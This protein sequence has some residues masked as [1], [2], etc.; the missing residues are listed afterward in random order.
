M[1]A[2]I[3]GQKKVIADIKAVTDGLSSGSVN[4]GF[5]GAERYPDG[6]PVAAVAY[7]N[8]FG[9]SKTPARPFFRNMI[10]KESSTWAPKIAALLK[11][12]SVKSDNVLG[13]M[14]EEIKGALKQS[15]QELKSPPLAASTIKAKGNAKPLVDSGQMLQAVDYEVVK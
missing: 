11:A 14:G 10:A 2:K 6:T 3:T 12:K 15:I 5:L 7:W 9:T 13:M 4:V 8:E 1:S